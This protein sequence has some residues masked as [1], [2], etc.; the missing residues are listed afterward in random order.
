MVSPVQKLRSL[1]A[2]WDAKA[3]QAA[4]DGAREATE[5]INPRAA[6]SSLSST[7]WMWIAMGAV[8]GWIKTK[9]QHAIAE[10]KSFDKTIR[11]MPQYFPEPWDAGAVESILPKLGDLKGMPWDKPL[12]DWSTKEMVRLAWNMHYLIDGAIAR[13][14]EGAEGKITKT[15]SRPVTERELSARQGGPLWDRKEYDDA[16]VPF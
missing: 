11:E 12:G 5:S 2:E 15:R 8:F 9:S 14:D 4:I 6:I 7:E 10:S 13:R 16:D 1:D 3:S